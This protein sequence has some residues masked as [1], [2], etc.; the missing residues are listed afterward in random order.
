MKHM[1]SIGSVLLAASTS[2]H[3]NPW[4]QVPQTPPYKNVADA[5]KA[6]TPPGQP[7]ALNPSCAGMTGDQCT[8]S[9]EQLA[10]LQ[11]QEANTPRAP[12]RQRNSAA[13]AY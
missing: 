13:G 7:S 3:A 9:A 4:D 11:P 2:A 8:R 1:L 6:T 12:R 10:K 5:V